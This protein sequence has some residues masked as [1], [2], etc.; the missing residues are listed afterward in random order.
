[1]EINLIDDREATPLVERGLH[2]RDVVVELDGHAVVR[3]PAEQPHAVG[4]LERR[5]LDREVGPQN[6]VGNRDGVVAVV[7]SD[8]RKRSAERIVAGVDALRLVVVVPALMVMPAGGKT[9]A[10]A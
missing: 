3:R 5:D 9:N 6:H 10:V 4:Y 7:G 8:V 2:D 1:M